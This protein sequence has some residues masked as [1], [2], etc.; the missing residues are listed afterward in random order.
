[1]TTSTKHAPTP[2]MVAV[3]DHVREAAGHLLVEAKAG[4]GKTTTAL[5]ATA[6]AKGDVQFVAFNK[7]IVVELTEKLE[8]MGS[9]AKANTFHS[10]G[11]SA[12]KDAM[13]EKRIPSKP[14]KVGDL[15]YND[16]HGIPN[17]L[18][19]YVLKLVSM[20]KITGIAL[21]MGPDYGDVEAWEQMAD[22]YDLD[23]A[24]AEDTASKLTPHERRLLGIDHA[25]TI[26]QLS[27]EQKMV[28]DFADML[29][30]PLYYNVRFKNRADWLFVDEAQDSSNVRLELMKRIV[31]PDGSVVCIGDRHQAIYGFAGSLTTAMDEIKATFKASELPLTVSFRC[32]QEVI[33]FAQQ[34]VPE[35]EYAPTAAVGEVRTLSVGEYADLPTS[36]WRF[37]DAIL[38]RFTKPLI[39][40]A[41]QFIR[42]RIRCHVEGRDI[43]AGLI[44]L[45]KKWKTVQTCAELSHHLDEYLVR[46]T[47]RLIAKR[48]DAKAETLKDRVE[49]VQIFIDQLSPT[50]TLHDLEGEISDLFEDTTGQADSLTLCTVHKSKGRE[51][52]RVHIL[53]FNQFMPAKFAKQEWQKAQER[54]LCYVAVT[55]ARQELILI[56]VPKQSRKR[57]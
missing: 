49:T 56:D 45:V 20:A 37:D 12:W 11:F 57:K 13:G 31:K 17:D 9:Q 14:G 50:S 6:H 41:Y 38:C 35:I 30:L 8:T 24:L 22:T 44:A 16:G 3:H 26:L 52:N 10:I 7:A 19:V 15:V 36:Y 48:Q 1:M 29:Y 40:Q 2:Q 23:D 42:Q 53:G 25:I 39:E 55:R 28:V 54:N 33:R 21:P 43:G 51:W 18:R 27:N 47:E 4:S 46:E 34:Y 5:G 32:P